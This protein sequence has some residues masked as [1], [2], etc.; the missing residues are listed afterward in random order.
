MLYISASPYVIGRT[1]VSGICF[2][3][4]V[5]KSVVSAHLSDVD[6]LSE[7]LGALAVPERR[8]HEHG[9]DDAERDGVELVHRRRHRGGVDALPL[10]PDGAQTLVRNHLTKQVLQTEK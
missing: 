7:Q 2:V 8:V 9:G 5:T 4:P 6:P 1:F 3:H 10:R